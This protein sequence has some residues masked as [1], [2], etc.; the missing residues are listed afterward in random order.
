[1]SAPAA[2]VCSSHNADPRKSYKDF[3]TDSGNPTAM[4]LA[5][6][7][8]RCKVYTSLSLLVGMGCC[9]SYDSPGL[10]P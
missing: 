5:A 10:H 4:L 2:T 3:V 1:M 7:M 9:L 6:Y 8:Y